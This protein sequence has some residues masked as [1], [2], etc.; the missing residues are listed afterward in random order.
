MIFFKYLPRI[1]VIRQGYYLPLLTHQYFLNLKK[2]TGR[3]NRLLTILICNAVYSSYFALCI[4]IIRAGGSISSM[5]FLVVRLFIGVFFVLSPAHLLWAQGPAFSLQVASC[6]F[7]G[8]AQKE[9]DRLK[10]HGIRAKFSRTPP[11]AQ[12]KIWY[13]ITIDSF[14]NREEARDYGNNLKA[15]KIIKNY[16]IF[17]QPA[18]KNNTINLKAKTLLP[19]EAK[20]S[21]LPEKRLRVDGPLKLQEEPDS[22]RLG[23]MVDPA[24]IP[25]VRSE[26]GEAGSR[27]IVTLKKRGQSFRPLEFQRPDGM[28]RSFSVTSTGAECVITLVLRSDFN[29]EV[30]QDY[31]EREMLYTLVITKAP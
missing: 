21:A 23:F 9:I 1:S 24:G 10:L 7:E 26:K 25:E 27:I 19:S 3:V 20:P 11:D 31:Y 17:N 15:K 8:S 12:K 2:F 28:L 16:K 4:S 18:E 14:K 29:Y 13:I 30:A 5:C 22:L 6:Q